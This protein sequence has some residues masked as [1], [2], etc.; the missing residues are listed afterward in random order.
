MRTAIYLMVICL[1]C[2]VGS[3]V[4]ANGEEDDIELDPS[5]GTMRVKQSDILLLP[6]TAMTMRND[7]IGNSRHRIC[8]FDPT[9]APGDPPVLLDWEVYKITYAAKSL[10]NSK[11]YNIIKIRVVHNQPPTNEDYKLKFIVGDVQVSDS[12]KVPLTGDPNDC[13]YSGIALDLF[14]DI[15]FDGISS[16]VVKKTPTAEKETVTGNLKYL[17]KMSTDP[18]VDVEPPPP[19]G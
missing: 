1:I 2:L 10:V 12:C 11:T 13:I 14:G 15:L 7:V 16:V 17:M 8:V 18:C 3:V 19:V 4:L 6:G 9:V 5:G